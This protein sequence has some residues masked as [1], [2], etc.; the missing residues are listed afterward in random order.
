MIDLSK[1]SGLSI[2]WSRDSETLLFRE[3]LVVAEPDVRRREEMIEVLFNPR[4]EGPEEL[5]YMYREVA[6][7][8]DREDIRTRGLR[9]DI[10]VIRPG[11]IGGEYVKT[12]GHYHPLKPG[13]A[14]TYPEVYE[15]LHGRA[16]YLLQRPAS[17]RV[18]EID[19]IILITARPGDKVLI[20]PGFGHITINPGEDPLIMSNWVAAEFSSIY[21]PFRVQGGGGYFELKGEKG[22]ELVPNNRYRCLPSLHQA[23][24][25]SFD[26]LSLISDLPIYRA[27]RQDPGSLDYLIKPEKFKERF[28][29]YQRLICPI[30]Q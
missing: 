25:I 30:K 26:E 20:P 11:I 9:Y 3:D 7:K 2:S 29:E 6:Y 10:T 15:V 8:K 28:E 18:D 13:T 27:Y 4:A 24:A 16:H 21:E 12:A 23:S 1:P 19:L 14:L 17:D 22:P 5:Y